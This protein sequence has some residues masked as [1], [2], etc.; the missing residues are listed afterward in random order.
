MIHLIDNVSKNNSIPAHKNHASTI[1]Q[2]FIPRDKPCVTPRA[3]FDSNCVSDQTE[4]NLAKV[5]EV[6]VHNRANNKNL[7]HFLHRYHFLG[8]MSK[9]QVS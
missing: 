3:S 9:I 2:E 7:P 6:F 4:M 5:R 1:F 8:A